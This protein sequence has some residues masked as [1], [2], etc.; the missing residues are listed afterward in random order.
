MVSA[1]AGTIVSIAFT[2]RS[3]RH[4]FG[5]GL[6]GSARSSL[7]LDHVWGLHICGSRRRFDVVDHPGR[8]WPKERRLSAVCERRAL[9][10]HGETPVHLLDFLGLYWLQS[11]YVDLVWQHSGRDGMVPSS[12]RR[13]VELPEHG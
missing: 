1:N 4:V 6:A 9:P 5:L 7:V 10:Y 8:S 3:L 2:I 11:I 13:I 12:K